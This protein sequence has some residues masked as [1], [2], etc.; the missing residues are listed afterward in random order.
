MLCKPKEIGRD[1]K[2]TDI[3]EFESYMPRHAVGLSQMQGEKP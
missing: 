3:Y 1:L 2:K